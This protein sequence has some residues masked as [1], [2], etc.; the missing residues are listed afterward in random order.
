MNLCKHHGEVTR[1]KNGN[2]PECNREYKFKNKDRVKENNRRY[3]LENKD[4]YPTPEERRTQ[5]QENLE[6]SREINRERYKKYRDRILT[7]C[8]KR[9]ANQKGAEINDL[10]AK[11]WKTILDV[12]DNKCFY[13]GDSELKLS[14]DH[15][16][17]L[18]KGG[19]HTALNIV[20][21]C[22]HCNSSKGA[23]S[24]DEFITKRINKIA[25][26]EIV[27]C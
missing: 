27:L 19:N 11:E 1:Y 3:Y 2:C 24:L 4:K 16:I 14:Q 17:P 23:Q 25:H 26:T 9:R 5:Y 6:K 8:H 22:V 20:P 15:V 21:A 10:K 13:C 7:C 18:S 12:Y